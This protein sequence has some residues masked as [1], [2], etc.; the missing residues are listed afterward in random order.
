MVSFRP[1][2]GG[3]ERPL[4]CCKVLGQLLRSC[5]AVLLALAVDCHALHSVLPSEQ[6]PVRSYNNG[7]GWIQ[8]GC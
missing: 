6:L 2:V 1:Y 8:A 3:I 7:R 5:K 4:S